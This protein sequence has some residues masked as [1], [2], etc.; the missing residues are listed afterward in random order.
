[1]ILKFISWMFVIGLLG[2]FIY[3][4]K[5]HLGN[6]WLQKKKIKN[7]EV[8]ETYEHLHKQFNWNLVIFFQLVKVSISIGIL[9]YLLG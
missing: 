9:Y 7:K 6:Y 1:M 3:S 4:T 5:Y 2:S 8:G